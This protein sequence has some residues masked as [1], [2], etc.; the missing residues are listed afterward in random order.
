MITNLTAILKKNTSP[1]RNTR[2]S[3]NSKGMRKKK[4]ARDAARTAAD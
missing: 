3:S 2:I 4:P 1:I